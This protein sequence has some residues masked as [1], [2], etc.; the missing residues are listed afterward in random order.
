MSLISNGNVGINQE[1]PTAKFQVSNGSILYD[2]SVGSTPKN[3]DNSELGAGTRLMWIPDKAAFRAGRLDDLGGSY[4]WVNDYWNSGNIGK[5]SFAFGLN[6]Q[7]TKITSIAMGDYSWVTDTGTVAIGTGARAIGKHSLA[8][9][10]NGCTAS[11][12]NAVAIGSSFTTASGGYSTAVGNV[13]VASGY[14][15]CSFGS[16][17]YSSGSHSTAMRDACLTTAHFS[18]AFG[19][20]VSVGGYVSNFGFGDHITSIGSSIGGNTGAF[21]IGSGTT[22]IGGT[23]TN[24]IN[25]TMMIG[26]HSPY[27]SIVLRYGSL[28]EVAK[29][30]IKTTSPCAI[31][32]VEGNAVVG[33]NWAGDGS[34]TPP[35]N[36]LVVEG[37]VGIGT[38]SPNNALSVVGS[39]STIIVADDNT[40][41]VT[42]PTIDLAV[43]NKAV[44]GG[45]ITLDNDDRYKLHVNGD[46]F[47]GGSGGAVWNTASD[48]RYKKNI[49]PFTD[50][51]SLLKQIRPIWFDYNGKMGIK[52]SHPQVG[53]IAQEIQKII[54]YT[55]SFDTLKR[56]ILVREEKRYEVDAFDTIV[57]RVPETTI[58]DSIGHYMPKDSTILK[59]IKKW[60]VDPPEFRVEK[61]EVLTYNANAIWYLLINSIKELDSS[62]ITANKE[63]KERLDS[64]E[65]EN[66]LTR[67]TNDSLLTIVNSLQ[68]RISRLEVQNNIS[69]NDAMDVIL[70][71]NNPNPFAEST[72]ITYYI[73]E[74]VNGTPELIITSSA[75]SQIKETF[76]LTKGIPIQLLVSAQGFNTGVYVYSIVVQNKILATKKFIIIK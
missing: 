61:E 33:S 23:L 54:P 5:Y 22:D 47:K 50:G 53:V 55:V 62:F 42:D 41:A 40:F 12:L 57:I 69:L 38:A 70:E 76:Q 52:S 60:V 58:K 28:T 71:Q 2:G 20:D 56:T 7:A 31:F 46:A 19:N 13:A 51:L 75:N 65:K 26:C 11:G 73:P 15:A 34:H 36:T 9:S 67:N 63:Y 37:K 72:T 18:G 17:V 32:S 27:P 48:I 66:K 39:E 29:V 21:T 10:T 24:T 68:D 6:C 45:N 30:G 16:N 49:S 59:P 35:A 74:T 64:I 3:V 14:M 1:I 25:N 8:F 44:I 43:Q 4:P